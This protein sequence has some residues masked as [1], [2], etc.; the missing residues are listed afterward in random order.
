M[1]CQTS[2]NSSQGGAIENQGLESIS[3]RQPRKFCGVCT[4]EIQ[5]SWPYANI[6]MFVGQGGEVVMGCGDGVLR[7][8][9]M[10]KPSLDLEHE[11][12]ISSK[13]QLIYTEMLLSSTSASISA[14]AIYSL[15]STQVKPG[16]MSYRW[17]CYKSTFTYINNMHVIVNNACVSHPL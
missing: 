3:N 17:L 11:T 13:L 6:L 7:L 12:R 4:K 1:L 10:E 8:W 9:D 16:K 2:I 15:N 14:V 5:T